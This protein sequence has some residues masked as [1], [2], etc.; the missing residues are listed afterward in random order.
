VPHPQRRRGHRGRARLPRQPEYGFY[1]KGLA[2]TVSRDGP[3][4]LGEHASPRP[5]RLQGQVALPRAHPQPRHRGPRGQLFQGDRARRSPP[6]TA[7]CRPPW[8]PSSRPSGPG[9]RGASPTCA[10]TASCSASSP[11][12]RASDRPPRRSPAPAHRR[13]P[14]I[15]LAAVWDAA[16]EDRRVFCS[17]AVGPLEEHL[18]AAGTP[19]LLR[20][21]V[22]HNSALAAHGVAAVL[23]ARYASHRHRRSLRGRLAA[24]GLPLA[25]PELQVTSPEAAFLRVAP[26]RRPPRS[27]AWSTR[28]RRAARVR[29]R[30]RLPPH[31][32]LRARRR[33]GPLFVLGPD[34]SRR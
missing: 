30:R 3:G 33:R 14:A 17:D 24:L 26:S 31:D 18:L 2:L 34:A 5:R 9:P 22:S 11:R 28:R 10:A 27:S 21:G 25:D 12:A 13:R 7:R 20:A 29:H 15:S 8:S 32:R 19:V 1:N 16:R 4:L 23:T 6:P